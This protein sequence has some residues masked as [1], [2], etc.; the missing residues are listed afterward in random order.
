MGELT[1]DGCTQDGYIYAKL[2]GKKQG[3]GVAGRGA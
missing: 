3:L 1:Q 2:S